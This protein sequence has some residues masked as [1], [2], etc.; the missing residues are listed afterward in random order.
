VPGFWWGVSKPAN[1]AYPV[2]TVAMEFDCPMCGCT[3]KPEWGKD[4]D[5]EMSAWHPGAQ[6][7]IT[8]LIEE[9]ACRLLD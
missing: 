5:A 3:I 8:T 4:R 7:C 1:K 6:L 2:D 9:A